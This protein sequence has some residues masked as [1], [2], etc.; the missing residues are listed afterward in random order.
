[1]MPSLFSPVAP[2][3][4]FQVWFVVYVYL[5]P[6][7]LYSSWATL[8]IMD[9]LESGE[10]RVRRLELLIVLIIPLLGAAWYLLSRARSF[11]RPARLAAVVVGLTVWIVP[12]AAAL[13]LVARPL[14]PKAL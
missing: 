7:L 9:M 4:L 1:M 12:L 2:S 14:G 8:S 13:Y 11:G 6:V 5:L 10:P 3:N